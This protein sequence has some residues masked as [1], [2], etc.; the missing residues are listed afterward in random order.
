MSEDTVTTTGR[1]P[2]KTEPDEGTTDGRGP[3]KTEPAT[4]TEDDGTYDPD[5]RGPS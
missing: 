1:G 4:T 2:S 5:G 3:S